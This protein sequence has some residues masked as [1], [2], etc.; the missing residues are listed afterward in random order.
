MALVLKMGLPRQGES[1][2][3]MRAPTSQLEI[4]LLVHLSHNKTSLLGYQLASARPSYSSDLPEQR[5][6]A[7]LKLKT[8]GGLRSLVLR[9]K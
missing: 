9:K 4:A 2:G 7:L 3:L 1:T 5:P 8:Y 6:H